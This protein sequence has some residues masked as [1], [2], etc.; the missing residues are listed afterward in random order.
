[1]SAD[2]KLEIMLG[3]SDIGRSFSDIAIIILKLASLLIYGY[4]IRKLYLASKKNAALNQENSRW[5]KNIFVIHM[6]YVACYSAYGFL[7][8]NNI[9]FGFLFQVHLLYHY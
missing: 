8:A 7:L 1:M 2:Q 6:L 3:R 5:Q 4:F 9:T